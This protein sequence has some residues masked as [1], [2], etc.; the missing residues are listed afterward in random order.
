MKPKIS[1]EEYRRIL[2]ALELS[3]LYITESS[4]KLR[5]EFFS[6]TLN[7]EI[8]EKNSFKQ[9][10]STLTV[11][12]NYKL[13]AKS[14]EMTE[15]AITIT[16]HYAVKYQISKDIVVSK[17]FMKVF[18]ELTVSMLLWTYFREFVN[19]T[20]YRMGMPALVLGL[21]KR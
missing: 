20:V 9:E 5:E 4:S 19:N 11:F 15:P 17:D 16:T 10:G 8:D 3:A 1:P 21:K 2:E 12:Y 13:S 14:V 6:N 18:S 7:V